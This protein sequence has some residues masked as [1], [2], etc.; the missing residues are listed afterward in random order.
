MKPPFFAFLFERPK[1]EKPWSPLDHPGLF[2]VGY[3]SGTF[4]RIQQCSSVDSPDAEMKDWARQA[5]A[6]G[7][8]PFLVMLSSNSAFAQAWRTDAFLGSL[9]MGSV[10]VDLILLEDILI[11]PEDEWLARHLALCGHQP[12]R[13]LESSELPSMELLIPFSH[14]YRQWREN[15]DPEDEED[16]IWREANPS[17]VQTMKEDWISV[18]QGERFLLLNSMCPLAFVEVKRDR[19]T[20]TLAAGGILDRLPAIHGVIPE[21]VDTQELDV[22]VQALLPWFKHETDPEKSTW[23]PAWLEEWLAYLSNLGPGYQFAGVAIIVLQTGAIAYMLATQPE[24]PYSEIRSPSISPQVTGPF[25]KV[26]FNPEAKESEIRHLLVSLGASFVDG[27][28]QLGD[29]ILLVERD[30]TDSAA[31]QLK[32]STIVQAVS[33]MATLPPAKE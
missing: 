31:Q 21:K 30:R 5:Q 10:E 22:E 9:L 6:L 17:T 27:P 2:Q 7:L 11:Y 8:T 20:A 15:L 3:R 24:V 28:S 23:M 14:A 33:I 26:S 19:D 1:A 16:A 18:G 13:R 32:Q 4:P 12:V 29:Y 25:I